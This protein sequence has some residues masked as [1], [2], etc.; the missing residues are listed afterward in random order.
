MIYQESR[1]GQRENNEDRIAY[2]YSRDALLLLLADGMGGHEYGEIAA[3][4]AIQFITGAFQE[5]A[6]PALADPVSFLSRSLIRAHE[7]IQDYVEE[8]KLNEIPRTTIVAC[9]IQHGCAWWAHAGDSRLYLLRGERIVERTRDHS[10]IQLLMDQGMLT[11]EEAKNYPGKNKI[12]SCLGGDHTPQFEFSRCH[13]LHDRDI[14]LLASD[15]LWGPL[16]ENVILETLQ[17]DTVTEAVPKLLKAAQAQAGGKSDNLSMIA[18]CWQDEKIF[19]G[20]EP[21]AQSL[22]ELES[23]LEDVS[24]GDTADVVQLSDEEIEQTLKEIDAVLK[25]IDN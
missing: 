21:L 11:A 10:R 16:D 23:L 24:P 19:A 6:R 8:K 9:V 15:G 12:Y 17:K 13:F 18:V 20:V 4:I 3:E 2:C 22:I 5:D 25:T 7:A 14:L 1:V